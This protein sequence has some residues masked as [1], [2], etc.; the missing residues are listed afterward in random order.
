MKLRFY[1]VIPPNPISIFNIPNQSFSVYH[2]ITRVDYS[3]SFK[4]HADDMQ[5]VGYKDL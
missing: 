3:D 2:A 1:F 4:D 5:R